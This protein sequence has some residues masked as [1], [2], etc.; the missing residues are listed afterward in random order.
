MKEY[1][2]K[3]VLLDGAQL[4][5]YMIDYDVG[6]A[7]DQVYELKKLDLDLFEEEIA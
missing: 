2:A 6:V 5:Q 7:P 4:A 3:I 1:G